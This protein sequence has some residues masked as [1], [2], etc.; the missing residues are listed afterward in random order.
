MLSQQAKFTS[1]PD[2]HLSAKG[3]GNQGANT[4]RPHRLSRANVTFLLALISHLPV[5][6]NRL[7][8]GQKSH[9]IIGVCLWNILNASFIKFL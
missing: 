2:G 6:F 9:S 4:L 8:R 7:L 5:S 3:G 1:L